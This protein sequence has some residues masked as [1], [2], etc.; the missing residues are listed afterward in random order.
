MDIFLLMPS[1]EPFH[2]P[3]SFNTW[4]FLSG[5]SLIALCIHLLLLGQAHLLT[6][7]AWNLNTL[8]NSPIRLLNRIEYY[9]RLRE[10]MP[11]FLLRTLPITRLEWCSVLISGR[12]AWTVDPPVPTQSRCLASAAPSAHSVSTMDGSS[13]MA[14][15]SDTSRTHARYAHAL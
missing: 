14:C 11:Q 12:E 13:Q 9:P 8:Q 4:V 3:A 2:S 6:K 15:S 1:G 10:F 5:T 7:Y